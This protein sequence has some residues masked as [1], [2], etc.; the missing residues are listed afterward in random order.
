[1]V[2]FDS[3]KYHQKSRDQAGFVLCNGRQVLSSLVLLVEI[4]LYLRGF[5]SG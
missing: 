2:G 4:I 3:G 5:S 1:M